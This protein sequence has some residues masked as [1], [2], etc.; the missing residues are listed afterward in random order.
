MFDI[1]IANRIVNA[2]RLFAMRMKI[3][4]FITPIRHYSVISI[5]RDSVTSTLRHAVAPM[6][7]FFL[8]SVIANAAITHYVVTNNALAQDPYT[9]WGIAG[10]NIIEVV[11]AAMTNGSGN[12]VLVSNGTY[13][14]TNQI[15]ITNGLVLQGVNGRTNT[16]INGNRLSGQ[17]N[18]CFYLDSSNAFV[19]CFTISNAGNV[20]ANGGGI[21]CNNG[22]LDNCIIT[23]NV[24]SNGGGVYMVNGSLTNCLII[25]NISMGTKYL[26]EGGGGIYIYGN[27]KADVFNCDIIS[28]Y[29]AFGGGIMYRAFVGPYIVAGCNISYNYTYGSSFGGGIIFSG[30]STPVPAFDVRNCVFSRNSASDGGGG[31]Y[32]TGAVIS[33]FS[34]CVFTT[35]ICTFS[36]GR[37]GGLSLSSGNTR[38]YNC[39]FYSNVAGSVANDGGA[40]Y[41]NS[42]NCTIMNCTIAKTLG[43]TTG[44]GLRIAVSN[45]YII[46]TIIYSNNVFDTNF[47]GIYTNCC[48]ESTNSLNVTSCITNNPQFMDYS[49]NNYRLAAASP[50]V[51]SG[52]NQSWMTNSIDLDGRQRI[53]YGT[54]DMGAYEAIYEGTI[55]QMG[56]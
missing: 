44:N 52:L 28:N 53:R 18:R 17:T 35:N 26:T 46:N 14:L 22:K 37:G 32:L 40:V 29:A 20:N 2:I 21:Y 51:N 34:N 31:V 11:N 25:T 24:S 10:T 8:F 5:L 56:F 3:K 47:Y 23:L 33:S 43:T 9:N 39:L 30:G 36:G 54:V 4:S 15:Y 1:S 49:E 42:T 27:G 41:V 45:A 7:A 19:K 48:L 38:L 16:F 50:C 12:T 6:F 55:Y 13:V